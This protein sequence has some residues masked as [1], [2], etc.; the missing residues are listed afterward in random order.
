MARKVSRQLI[1]PVSRQ[2]V[3]STDEKLLAESDRPKEDTQKEQDQEE[4]RN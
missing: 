1:L 2:E 4:V 3:S